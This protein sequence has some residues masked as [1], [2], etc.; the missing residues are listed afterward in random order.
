VACPL[1]N[2][3]LIDV[4]DTNFLV[5][6]CMAPARRHGYTF[7]QTEITGIDCGKKQV[8]TAQG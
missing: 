3:W 1:S 7:V 2:K 8:H 4:V 6:S 5:H